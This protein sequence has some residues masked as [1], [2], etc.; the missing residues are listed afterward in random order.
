M[1]RP[2]VLLALGDDPVAH[3]LHAALL[4]HDPP[5]RVQTVDA[6]ALV[7]AC[8]T[9]VVSLVVLSSRLDEAGGARTLRELSATGQRPEVVV[10]FDEAGDKRRALV[11]QVGAYECVVPP[12]ADLAPLL[13]LVDRVIAGEKREARLDASARVFRVLVENSSDGIYIL[14][15]GRFAYTNKRF[16]QMVGYSSAELQ[17]EEFELEEITAPES[18]AYVAERGRKAAKGIPL[19]PRYEFVAQRRGGDRFDAQI[20]ISYIEF[21]GAAASLGIIQDITERKQFEQQLLRKNRELALLNDLAA[22]INQAVALD[23]TLKVGCRGMASLLGAEAA[24]ITLLAEDGRSLQLAA[25][26]GLDDPVIRALADVGHDDHSLLAS[27]VRTGEVAVVDDVQGD[28]RV[29][30]DAVRGGRFGGCIV[31]P[32]KA[33]DRILGA[34]FAFTKEGRALSP[35]D[36]DVMV[37]IGTLLGNAIEKASLL[38]EERQNVRRLTALDEIGVALASTLDM[39]EVAGIVARQVHRLFGAVRVMIA[40]VDDVGPFIPMHVLDGG[41]PV[42]MT[43]PI[44]RADT[45]MDLALEERRPVQRIRPDDPARASIDPFNGKPVKLLRYEQ[46]MFRQGVGTGVAVPILEGGMPVGALWLGYARALPLSEADLSVL[47]SLGTHV[48][49]A[50]KNSSLFAARNRA[51]DDLKAAQVKLVEAERL[52]AIAVIAAGVAHDFNNVLGA[53]LGRA[54]LLK[55]QLRDP[56]LKKH[57]EIIETA[58]ND[59]AETVRRIQ[60]IGK[61][62][63]LD[64]FV[65]VRLDDIAGDVVELTQPKW[66]DQPRAQGRTIECEALAPGAARPVVNGNPHELREVLINLVHNAVDAMPAGGRITLSTSCDDDNSMCFVRVADTGTG[67]PDDV[68][69]R[70]FDPFFTTKG[71]RGT[72]LGLSVSQSII[73]RHGGEITVESRTTG[74]DRGTTFVIALPKAPATQEEQAPAAAYAPSGGKAR[75]LVIDDEENIRDILTDILVTGDHDVVTAADG[76][77]GLRKLEEDDFDL[78]FTDLGL[79]GMSG[80]DVA[81]AVK[82]KRPG[83]PVGLVTGWGA[84]LDPEKAKAHGV[85]LVLS[86]PF[87]FD[88]V[89][90]LV[91]QALAARAVAR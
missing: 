58:A 8:A 91:D 12:D 71:E 29:A 27:T 32:V 49:I 33:H 75:V 68:R 46:D 56:A 6:G 19:E 38:D 57:A 7:D 34:A 25:H 66:R 88:Q 18:R 17:S 41:E 83:V 39:D 77:E 55:T 11:S 1:S 21:E 59:G 89:L 4:D 90:K 70:I 48:A 37:S 9:E 50:I 43:V 30:I 69:E 67:M 78:V 61:Q 23:E 15:G 24:G 40:R 13:A 22:S 51:L 52:N 87:R 44:P 54:Q 86:K 35:E 63:R 20:S 45:I 53:I 72:G 16:Q 36:R 74:P 3:G 47:S 14:K 31:V 79:P 62:E 26:E 64:D 5:L 65:P 85:D 28:R 84:T 82:K 2:L 76:Q 42:R 10:L 60:Q 80:Y 73:R 81:A